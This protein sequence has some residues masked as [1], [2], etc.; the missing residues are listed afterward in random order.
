MRSIDHPGRD[1]DAW[2]LTRLIYQLSGPSIG[3]TNEL[4]RK[5]LG[6]K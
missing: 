1:K 4:K 5:K 2:Q 6:K 3:D